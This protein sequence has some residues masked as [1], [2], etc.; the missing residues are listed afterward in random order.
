ML[1][2]R[3]VDDECVAIFKKCPKLDVMQVDGKGLTDAAIE[4]LKEY[5]ALTYLV[6]GDTN[7]VDG[8]RWQLL[9]TAR[10]GMRTCLR[11]TQIK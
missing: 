9:K 2:V 11:G 5:P 3:G 1:D 10:P 4:S 8:K 6:L 7:K